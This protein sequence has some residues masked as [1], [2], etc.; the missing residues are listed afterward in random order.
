[1]KHEIRLTVAYFDCVP[2]LSKQ[3][4][5]VENLENIR[6]TPNIRLFRL[7]LSEVEQGAEENIWAE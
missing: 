7:V 6:K 1:M 4:A 3:P 5:D 2:G